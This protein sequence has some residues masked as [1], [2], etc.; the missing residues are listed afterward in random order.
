MREKEREKGRAEAKRLALSL[1]TGARS[2]R[3]GGWRTCIGVS[4]R[5]SDVQ[6]QTRRCK[7]LF[8]GQPWLVCH[9]V[10]RRSWRALIRRRQARHGL[11]LAS[12]PL[13]AQGW[14]WEC[15]TMKK[16]EAAVDDSARDT[17]EKARATSSR[18][19]TDGQA[20]RPASVP[21]ACQQRKSR[22]EAGG[23]HSVNGSSSYS[24][25]RALAC[26]SRGQTGALV[27]IEGVAQTQQQPQKS[28]FFSLPFPS[29][30]PSKT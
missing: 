15:S 24:C 21:A 3:K 20:K 10:R 2:E 22:A 7:T 4:T 18:S 9:A 6:T 13:I 25:R 23:G 28:S 16:S 17:G 19:T 11:R 1:G 5:P 27:S 26:R 12:L 30:T 14:A 29:F 8:E